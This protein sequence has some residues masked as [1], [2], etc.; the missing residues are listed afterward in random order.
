M[1]RTR[2]IPA[3]TAFEN[4]GSAGFTASRLV[5]VGAA[6]FTIVNCALEP[7]TWTAVDLSYDG[8]YRTAG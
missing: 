5:L 8:T 7:P 3:P 6:G 2:A 4:R 1:F